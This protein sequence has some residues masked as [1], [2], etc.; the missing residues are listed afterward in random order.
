MEDGY[1]SDCDDEDLTDD[2]SQTERAVRFL[3][4][5]GCEFI[6]HGTKL[7]PISKECRKLNGGPL[8]EFIKRHFTTPTYE[9]YI[10]FRVDSL[11]TAIQTVD[12]L[13]LAQHCACFGHSN[14]YE[15]TTVQDDE[16]KVIG[17]TYDT[18]SG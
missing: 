2:L 18:E 16:Y 11:Y 9:S 14:L 15:I 12:H 7:I 3:S 8:V 17:L 5:K 10:V 1:W 13:I 6:I 4:S